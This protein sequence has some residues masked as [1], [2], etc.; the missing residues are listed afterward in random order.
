[1]SVGITVLPV[2]STWAV[3]AG[4]VTA[5]FRPIAVMRPFC[6][7][8]APLSI[9]ALR[10]PTISLAPSYTVAVRA[11]WE[12]RLATDNAM[13]AAAAKNF[14]RTTFT[15]WGPNSCRSGFFL[16]QSTTSVVDLLTPLGVVTDG[17]AEADPARA[18]N[19]G[20]ALDSRRVVGP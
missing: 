6:T 8:N 18:A 3:L 16:D 5:S 7:T 10:S 1:M 14:R 17:D 9:G 2:R 15:S 19:H 13:P 11:V 20:R 12:S 4:T